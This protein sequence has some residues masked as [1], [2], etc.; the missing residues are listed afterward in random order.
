MK[1][2]KPL[3]FA[4]IFFLF[5]LAFLYNVI[6]SRDLEEEQFERRLHGSHMIGSHMIGSNFLAIWF[7]IIPFFILISSSI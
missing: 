4:I 1:K 5:I 7:F 6:A 3:I 2:L